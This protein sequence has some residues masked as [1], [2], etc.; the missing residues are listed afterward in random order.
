MKIYYIADT[1]L[2]NKS[3][4]SQHVIKMC[5]GFGQHGCSV[6]LILPQKENIISFNYLKK[7]FLLKSKIPFKFNGILKKKISHFFDRFLF[8]YKAAKSLRKE[9]NSLILTRSI[10]SSVFL[11]IFKKEHFL[12]IHNEQRSFSK[13]LMINLNFINSIYVKRI[14]FISKALSKLYNLEKKKF[15]ILHDATDPKNFFKIKK[16]KK[17]KKVTYIGSF[18]RG[19]GIELILKLSKKFNKIQFNLYGNE[20]KETKTNQKNLKIFN[21]IEYFRV[22]KILHNSDVL[23]MPYSRNV[24]IRAKNVNTANYCSPLK[25]FDYLA[26][27][28]IIISSKLDGISEILEHKK[29]AILVKD[30]NY[31]SWEKTIKKLLNNSYDILRLQK[32][33]SNMAKKYSWKNRAKKIIDIK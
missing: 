29:N 3:A 7:K 1:S 15:I 11:T 14:I 20:N 22:P 31:Y 8:G 9:N 16:I 4:Y 13:F 6:D 25:M 30:F 24:A 5:D 17:I 12:E 27:G 28:K 19:R 2:E 33:S 10:S 26:A 23:L 21:H 18:L 32:N